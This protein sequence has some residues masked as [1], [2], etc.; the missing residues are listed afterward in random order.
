[1]ASEPRPGVALV[2]LPARGAGALAP[3]PGRG[4][5]ARDGPAR[6]FLYDP[7]AGASWADRFDVEGNPRARVRPGRFTRITYLEDGE[8]A[9]AR[10]GVHLRRRVA[11]EPAYLRHLLVDPARGL[12]RRSSSPLA[13]YVAQFDTEELERR[14]AVPVGG[15]R[16]RHAPTRG[17]DTRAGA[18][19]PRPPAR[20]ARAPGAGRLR[21]RLRRASGGR[22]A[23]GGAGRSRTRAR[24]A[25]AGARRGALERAQ[26]RRARGDGAARG[27]AAQP[28]RARSLGC[29]ARPGGAAGEGAGA[30]GRG[31]ARARRRKRRRRKKRPLFFDEPYIDTILCTSCNECTN[32]NS[33]LFNYNADKQAFIAD[34][35]AGTFADLVKAAGLCP[36]HCIHPGKPRGDDATATPELIA[37]AAKFN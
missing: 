37:R 28:G 7:D 35:A 17:R 32:I 24:R 11:L 31:R 21:E 12:G 4:R 30:S 27:D 26:R 5:T 16:R 1:M 14:G 33:R 6:D 22:G 15:R 9:D 20:L 10:A 36:A 34:A 29:G 13:E 25:R 23:G 19:L 3:A 8:R 18:G 2:P